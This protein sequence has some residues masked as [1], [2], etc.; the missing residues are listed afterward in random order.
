MLISMNE[1][2][3]N[4]ITVEAIK[5]GS[6]EVKNVATKVTRDVTDSL[7]YSVSAGIKYAQSMQNDNIVWVHNIKPKNAVKLPDGKL[8]SALIE[9]IDGNTSA[10]DDIH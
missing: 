6:N 3:N 4:E 2:V 1:Y 10:S 5:E 7:K 8:G 9:V